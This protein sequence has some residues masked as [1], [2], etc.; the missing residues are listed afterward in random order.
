MQRILAAT[1]ISGLVIS[2]GLRL[3]QRFRRSLSGQKRSK[4]EGFRR[5][6]EVVVMAAIAGGIWI[7]PLVYLLTDWFEGFDYLLP[8]RIAWPGIGVFLAGIVLRWAAQSALGSSWSPTL[9]T[10]SHQQLVTSGVYRWIRHPLYSS[11]ILWAIAQPLL[12]QN[13]VAG[14]CGA[15]AV[16]LIWLVRVPEEE[17]M[18]CEKFGA[19]YSGI[20]PCR[21][22]PL[23]HEY[24]LHA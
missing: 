8:N 22:I 16:A 9:E 1:Y 6:S 4:P 3:P 24:I 17:R 10:G 23:L 21:A 18:M 7:L 11:L 12:L 2:E 5:V 13:R 19:A 20:N 14:F 15:V